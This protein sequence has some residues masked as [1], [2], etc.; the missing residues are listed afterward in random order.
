MRAPIHV[1]AI[2]GLL[3]TPSWGAG[4]QVPGLDL[5]L[6][7]QQQALLGCGEF[8]GTD[9]A[10]EGIELLNTEVS[11][12]LQ[13]FPQVSQPGTTWP[14]PG[15]ATVFLPGARGPIGTRGELPGVRG[16]DFLY[17]P[18]VDGGLHPLAG[19][20]FASELSALSWNYM[21]LLVATSGPALPGEV[22]IDEFDPALPF[23]TDGCSFANPQA[24]LNVIGAVGPGAAV[25]E[26]GAALLFAGGF[27]LVAARLRRRRD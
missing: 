13:S 6:T 5:V 4:I 2:L 1:L 20:Q 15:A 10:V 17:D 11:T 26:P 9:C 7:D 21:M 23:R 12:I 22:G 18:I 19:Q 8:Y 16:S 27:A 14:D 24:C 25:P 3:A